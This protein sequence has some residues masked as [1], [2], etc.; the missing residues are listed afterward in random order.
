MKTTLITLSA[1]LAGLAMLAAPGTARAD[2]DGRISREEKLI[3]VLL[4]SRDEDDRED[5]AEDLEDFG[6]RRALAAL[7]YAAEFDEDGDVRKEARK[8]ARKISERLCTSQ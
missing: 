3:Q 2:R 6:S 4:T 1:I 7:E 5:A 8:S